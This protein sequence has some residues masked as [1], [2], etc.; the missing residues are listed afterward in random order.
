MLPA[1]LLLE[2]LLGV[3]SPVVVERSSV[4][5]VRPPEAPELWLDVIAPLRSA[6]LVGGPLKT[7]IS[8]PTTSARTSAVRMPVIARLPLRPR[9]LRSIV[10]LR[11]PLAG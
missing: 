6:V 1:L 3:V 9:V 2:G 4:L 10:A 11:W 5:P 8:P 7:E